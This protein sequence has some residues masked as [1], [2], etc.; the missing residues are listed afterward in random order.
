MDTYSQS[1]Q[2]IFVSKILKE[3]RNGYFLEIGSNHPVQG[4]NTYLLEKKYN[5]KGLMVEYDPQFAPLYPQYRPNSIYS[6]NDAR[7]VDY[8]KIM[9][10]NNFPSNMDYLQIDLDVDNKSTLDTLLLLNNIVFDKYKFATVTF[11][12]DIYRGDFF[13]TRNISRQILKDRGYQLVFPDIAV[14]WE[15]G[16]KQYEDWYIHPDLVDMEYV[17]K[18]KSDISLTDKQILEILNN[19]N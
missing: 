18:V 16:Y 13:D 3:K 8:R 9:D 4:N 15:G 14:F 11:E 12:H 6:I 17:N 5:W 1:F 19:T 10:M 7:R 2:D